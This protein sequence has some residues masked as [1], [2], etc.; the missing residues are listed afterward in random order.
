MAEPRSRH[1]P[2]AAK[3]RPCNPPATARGTSVAAPA[4]AEGT[5]T[6][7]HTRMRIRG[8]RVCG[9]RRV[10]RTVGRG[11]GIRNGDHHA[12]ATGRHAAR[13]PWPLPCLPSASWPSRSP[14]YLQR[15]LARRK[16]RPWPRRGAHGRSSP[17]GSADRG[18]G[19]SSRVA[20]PDNCT[21]PVL[22]SCTVAACAGPGGTPPPPS[23]LA[24]CSWLH[25]GR[26]QSRPV[27]LVPLAYARSQ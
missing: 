5:R 20:H 19:D 1:D 25:E 16:E 7:T 10:P 14:T 9:Y 22:S 23:S 26:A 27:P 24:W 11:D 13:A 3:L 12:M 2:W 18:R 21:T 8:V 15:V 4:T 17:A 6:H